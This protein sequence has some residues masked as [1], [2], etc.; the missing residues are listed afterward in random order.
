MNNEENVIHLKDY[1]DHSEP[2]QILDHVESD[3]SAMFPKTNMFKRALALIV[4][5]ST[6]TV[7][8]VGIHNGYNLFVSEFL[9]PVNYE[10][11]YKLIQGDMAFSAT[12][13][14]VLYFSYFLYCTYIM[15][16]KTLGKMAMGLT[17]IKEN[18]VHNMK[19]DQIHLT[20]SES[21]KRAA[22]YLGCL[23]SFGVFFVFTFASEDNRGLADYLSGSRTVSDKW[24]KQMQ[25]FKETQ[26][27]QVIIDISRLDREKVAA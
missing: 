23:L 4:D 14:L 13:Y 8:N 22:G 12:I 16:G 6:L 20:F 5:L 2:I 18:Y 9:G 15:N 7:L 26:Q 10:N 3:F 27:E 11:Q 19:E 21:A 24:L 17:V 1:L 25:E